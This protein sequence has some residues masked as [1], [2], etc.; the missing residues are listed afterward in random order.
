MYIIHTVCAR[1]KNNFI[2]I[3]HLKQ[4]R[5]LQHIS[6]R[7]D[8]ITVVREFCILLK[9]CLTESLRKLHVSVLRWTRAD[10]R[11]SNRCSGN[12]K[13]VNHVQKNIFRNMKSSEE[14]ACVLVQRLCLYFYT[15][16]F[17]PGPSWKNGR[18]IITSF[19]YLLPVGQHYLVSYLIHLECLTKN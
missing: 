3:A 15:I 1:F 6:Y 8:Y 19:N 14:R 5:F 4:P 2:L 18:T 13:P 11:H 12:C 7:K 17:E 16:S 9:I 10:I